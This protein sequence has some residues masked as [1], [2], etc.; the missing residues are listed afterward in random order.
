M[1]QPQ[2]DNDRE[3]QQGGRETQDRPRNAND[4][5]PS[6]DK[7]PDGASPDRQIAQERQQSSG[8]GMGQS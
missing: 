5:P 7:T 3:M 6:I 8:Q 4:G 1:A 2:N